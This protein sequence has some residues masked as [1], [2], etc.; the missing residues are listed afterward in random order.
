MLLLILFALLAGAATALSPC[1]LPILP[2]VA[3]GGLTGGRR[4]PLGIV[5]G[6]VLSFTFVAVAL[7]YVI[8]ALGLPDDIQR[9]VAIVVLVVF[10]VAL[11]VPAIGD[12]MEARLSRLVGAPR[13]RNREGLSSGLFLGAGLGLIYFP[14]AGPILAG[15][16]TVSAAQDFTVGRL[17]VAL[18]YAIGSGIVLYALLRG[19]RRV[20]EFI[21]PARGRIQAAMGVVMV[22]VALLLAFDVDRRYTNAIAVG[23]PDFITNPTIGLEET[24]AVAAELADVRE[25]EGHGALTAEAGAEQADRGSSLPI[26]APAPEISQ[27]GQFFNTAD[28]EPVSIADLNAEGKTVLIDFWTYTC[29]N[30][31]RTLPVLEALY[32][33]YESEGLVIVGV[34]TPEFPFERDPGNVADAIEQNG[35]TYPVVQDNDYGTW[36]AFGNQYWPA[37]YLIDP[38]GRVRYAHFGEGAYET[39]ESAIRSLLAESEG[40]LGHRARDVD[41]ETAD[42]AVRTPETYLGALRAE[43][44]VSGDRA[45][46]LRTGSYDFGAPQRGLPLNAFAYSGGW[47]IGDDEATALDE[48]GI[49]ATFRARSVF[50]VLGSPGREREVRVLLDGEPIA[51]SDA[52]RDVSGGVA[53]ISSER[54]Y[55][56]VDLPEAGEHTLTLELEDG[57]SGYAFTFG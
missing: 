13:V 5:I 30:C 43:G 39:T 16:I 47:R 15:I 48:G 11:L 7:V 29:I 44:W 21:K 3:A 50:L 18:S 49:V 23:L 28:G 6:L 55:R 36:N 27:P 9:T 53:S 37:K 57:I 22:A 38:E 54:L 4:R 40:N 42:P 31:I 8:D 41:P 45:G 1:V 46:R 35:L 2:V 56:L 12:R 51:D 14:C 17:A 32:E 10:G 25:A 34:H 20:M 52:G 33:R 24:D 26:L 19:G